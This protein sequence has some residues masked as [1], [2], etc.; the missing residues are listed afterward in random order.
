MNETDSVVRDSLSS[1][2]VHESFDIGGG[3]PRQSV[4]PNLWLDVQADMTLA[5]TPMSEAASW[6]DDV[7]EPAVKLSCAAVRLTRAPTRR[8]GP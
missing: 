7:G 2:G 4:P 8:P 3:E 1:N 6:L 5:I